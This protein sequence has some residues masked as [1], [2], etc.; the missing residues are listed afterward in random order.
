MEV[1]IQLRV[2][3][4]V[5]VVHLIFIASQRMYNEQ[6]AECTFRPAVGKKAKRKSKLVMEPRN[7]RPPSALPLEIVVSGHAWTTPQRRGDQKRGRAISPLRDDP[8]FV[9]GGGASVAKTTATEYGSI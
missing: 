5:C 3:P 7:R 6:L 2:L 8:S 1:I 9:G 4:T